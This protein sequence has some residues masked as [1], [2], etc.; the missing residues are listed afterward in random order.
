MP[1]E[2]KKEPMVDIDTSGPEVEVNLEEDKR[3]YDSKKDHGNDISYEN[4]TEIEKPKEEE[5]K[6]EEVKEET[7]PKEETEDNKK[8]LEDYSESV[9][10]RIAKLTKKWREAERQKEA[11]M[12]Y[13]KG[14]KAEQESLKTKLSTIEPNYLTAMEGRVTSGLQAA[15]AALARAREAGDIAA[16][17]E[18]QKMI[19]R[20]GVEEARVANLKKSFGGVKAVD[21]DDL[22][23]ES[24]ELTSIIGP[25]GAG[26]TTLFDLISGFQEEDNGEIFYKDKNITKSQP[27]RIARLGMVRTFQLTKV[28]DRMTVLE[29]LMFAGSNV[30]NDSLF[31]SFMQLSKQKKYENSLKEEAM[32]VMKDLNIEQMSDSYARELSGGQ[33]K[34]LELGRS[35]IKKPEVLLLD[36]PLAGVNPKLAEDLLEIIQSLSNQGITILMVEHNIEA[37]MKI[38]ER[39]VVLAEGALIADGPPQEVR[40]N[41]NVIE[42]YLGTGD[43]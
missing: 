21:I 27:Y 32:K 31:Q 4:E 38:S 39:V 35:I 43:E 36:E 13:A 11:A 1:E 14:V 16:E 23:F 42:A 20:L 28:F 5:V 25:N 33:K 17:V 15:Q 19:A 41:Q 2:Q 37:V 34:L 12:E 9:Q 29:N 22:S 8:E 18:A 40:E 3:T 30:S 6:V 7:K 26:K 10:K 24:K